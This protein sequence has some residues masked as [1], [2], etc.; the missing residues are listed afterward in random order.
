MDK[1]VISFTS[2]INELQVQKDYIHQE[3]GLLKS[4]LDAEVTLRLGLEEKLGVSYERLSAMKDDL[5]KS[6]R[7]EMYFRSIVIGYSRGLSQVFP[8]I[9]EMNKYPAMTE[10]D[11]I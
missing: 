11:F 9:Q 7:R 6:Y 2:R 4:Q 10:G 3:L 8:I 5:Q 1:D